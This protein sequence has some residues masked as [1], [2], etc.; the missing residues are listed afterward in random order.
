MRSIFDSYPADLALHDHSHTDTSRTA[1]LFGPT[2][3]RR[4]TR[5]HVIHH[6]SDGM[7]APFRA[8]LIKQTKL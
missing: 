7:V 6:L 2:T 4:T 5:F 8:F 3:F 1:E